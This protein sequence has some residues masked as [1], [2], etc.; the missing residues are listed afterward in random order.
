MFLELRRLQRALVNKCVIGP[1]DR[2]DPGDELFTPWNPDVQGF[3][4]K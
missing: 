4:M 2:N 3:K 1:V